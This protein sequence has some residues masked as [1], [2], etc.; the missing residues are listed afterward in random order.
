MKIVETIYLSYPNHLEKDVLRPTVMALGFFDGVHRGHQTV[1]Q[2]A[3]QA[4]DQLNIDC[5]VMTFYPH[6][7]EVLGIYNDKEPFKYITPL[8]KKIKVIASQN[9]DRLYIVKFDHELSK[10]TPQQFVDEFL[11]RLNVKHVVAGFDYTYGYMGKGTMETLPFHSR[12]QFT[13]STVPKVEKNHEKISSTL[14]R[15]NLIE[16]KVEYAKELLG[17]FYEIEGTVVD[18][19]KRGRTIGFPTANIKLNLPFL[20]PKTGVYAVGLTLN[21]KEHL[22]V[23]NIGYKPTFHHHNHEKTIEVHLF[24]FD[25]QIYGEEVTVTF[26]KFLRDEQKFSSINELIMQINKDKQMAEQFFLNFHSNSIIKN[27]VN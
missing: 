2:T 4:A 19:E 12:E 7:K 14:I 20:T 23:C 25:Q 22:G 6:P 8:E 27:N 18:G 16:G 5:S 1:I 11:I 26:Y 21:G 3:K 10:L 13:H 17:R 15:S 9:V 24:H